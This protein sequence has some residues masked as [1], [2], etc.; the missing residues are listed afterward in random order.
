M[1]SSSPSLQLRKLPILLIH[2]LIQ[3]LLLLLLLFFLLLLHLLF[4][5]IIRACKI[6]HLL[7]DKILFF[8]TIF[9][10]F[11]VDSVGTD[12]V[13]KKDGFADDIFYIFEVLEWTLF[14]ILDTVERIWVWGYIKLVW[15]LV[16]WRGEV[17]RFGSEL[18]PHTCLLNVSCFL[19]ICFSIMRFVFTFFFWIF[20]FFIF[21]CLD[22]PFTIIVFR[23]HLLQFIQESPLIQYHRFK[24]DPAVYASLNKSNDLFLATRHVFASYE[25]VDGERDALGEVLEI[26][27]HIGLAVLLIE[28]FRA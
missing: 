7:R 26:L 9:I 18:G 11:T 8:Q 15:G 1:H 28:F 12:V 24:L 17:R 6:S 22:Y 2:L 25:V 3:L 20:A 13:L 23:K 27:L 14:T 5:P 4:F 10:F 21:Y 16:V 19:I